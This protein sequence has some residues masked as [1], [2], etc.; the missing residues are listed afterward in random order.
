MNSAEIVAALRVHYGDSFKIIEQV[1]DHTGGRASR[2]I[3]A[4][5]IGLWPSRGLE[6]HAI[7]VKVSRGD[8]RREIEQPEKA[9]A[10]ARYCD[11]FWLATPAGIVDP[12]YLEA[13]VPNWGLLEVVDE[14]GRRIVKTSRP[15]ARVEPRRAVDRDLLAAILRKLPSLTDDVR[16]EVVESIREEL[17]VEAEARE[18]REL[19]RLRA[20]HDSL[21][22]TVK[23]FE[24]AS[25]INL[26]AAGT[27]D[28]LLGDLR[29]A[30]LGA[31]VALLTRQRKGDRRWNSWRS[32]LA[33]RADSLDADAK[34]LRVMAEEQ[35]AAAALLGQ[36]F[37]D[38]ADA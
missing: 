13:V 1:A 5:A 27:Y 35:R 16:R 10:I 9:E 36:L 19:S 25:G 3:D 4:L 8:L 15:A 37:R 32:A 30:D 29:P 38:D 6:L 2:W 12:A 11:R 22:A 7:E 23:A 34:A 33:S 20:E 18:G 17:R 24:D 21:S 28:P 14:R 31:T 26:R